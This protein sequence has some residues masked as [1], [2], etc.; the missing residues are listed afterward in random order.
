MNTPIFSE[1][2]IG[3]KEFVL[4]VGFFMMITAAVL[5]QGVVISIVYFTALLIALFIILKYSQSEEDT[6]VDPVTQLQ[7]KYS[8]DEISK[9]EFEEKL[10][11]LVE[12]Q[13]RSEEANL[14]TE[15]LNL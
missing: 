9:T 7:Q 2:I 5:S 3:E 14:E 4:V 1:N 11:D 13:K 6:S 8:E 15:E 10:D 12:S